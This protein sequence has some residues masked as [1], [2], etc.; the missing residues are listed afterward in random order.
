[1]LCIIWSKPRL[2]RH[3]KHLICNM[4]ADT[5]SFD[6]AYKGSVVDGN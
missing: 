1:M 3:K 6:S 2:T 4:S 5:L